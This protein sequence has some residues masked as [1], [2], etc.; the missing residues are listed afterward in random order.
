MT[1]KTGHEG[2]G[3]DGDDDR[4]PEQMQLLYDLV[5]DAS[6]P[7]RAPPRP[8][9]HYVDMGDFDTAGETQPGETQPDL[10]TDQF[11]EIIE[12]ELDEDLFPVTNTS[13]P[14][15]EITDGLTEILA[16]LTLA[17]ESAG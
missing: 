9:N 7:L 2:S 3:F 13:L 11:G 1:D 17:P 16:D 5:F 10:L 6:L 4:S 8:D 14:I 15:E 12:E